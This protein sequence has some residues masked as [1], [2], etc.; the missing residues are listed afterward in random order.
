M[1][2]EAGIDVVDSLSDVVRRAEVVIS[3]VSTAAASEVADEY[4]RLADVAPPSAIFVDAN[5]VGPELTDVLAAKIAATGR[6]FV[7][8]AINGLAKNLTTSGTLFLSGARSNEI[9]ALFGDAVRVRVLGDAPGRAS[10][11]KML[12]GGM[13]KGLCA[14]FLEL[15]SMA[16]QRDMLPE[17]LEAT[18]AIY[19][20]MMMV[21]DRMLPTYAQHA[22]RRAVEMRE[23]ER[24]LEHSDIRPCLIE[25][26]RELHDAIADMQFDDKDGANVK[27]LVEKATSAF[28]DV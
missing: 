1:A 19:P 27:A 17:M 23:L 8:A 12:L 14:L 9:A 5:S 20:G 28:V 6:D 16:Q 13:S 3:L 4:C 22:G 21:I 2:R 18:T 7:D 24:T 26:V 15:A 10:A 11:M 25:A